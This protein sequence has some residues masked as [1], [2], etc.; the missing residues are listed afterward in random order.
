MTG[1]PQRALLLV[2][3][4]LALVLLI[5]PGGACPFCGMQ[6]P[7][8]TGEVAQAKLV[9]Y[10]QLANAKQQNNGDGTT[11][12]VVETI[13]K[14][15]LAGKKDDL[16]AGTKRTVRLD[17]Y[18]P[19]QAEGGKYRYL[20]YCDVFKGKIDPYRVLPVLKDGDVAKY[21]LGALKHKDE[22]IGKRL[23]FFFDYL[24]NPDLEISNDAYKEFGNADYKD[25]KDMAKSLPAD[26][27]A[28]WLTD[29]KTPAFRYGLYASM[30]GHCGNA[31]HA[32][33]LRKL[34]DDP[35][36]RLGSGVDGMLAGYVMLKPKEGWA[37]TRDILKDGK[38]EFMLRY[39]ALRTVRFLWDSRP[40]LVSKKERTAGMALLLDQSDIADLAVDDMRKRECWDM[41]NRV[42][43]L[44]DTKAYKE[45]PIVRRA[46]LRYALSCKGN[47]VATAYVAEQRKQDAQM[48]AD[49]EELLKL[50]QTPP[51]SG[52]AK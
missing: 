28:K 3:A 10:G 22:T 49:A 31:K 15:E 27:V 17:R 50:E 8:M 6:G 52:P 24:D 39:A 16:L 2:I 43:S 37:Y 51:T 34:L 45:I 41:A 47:A 38:K 14:N 12:L 40:D 48:V 18:L 42:L 5:S 26:R 20:V 9:L 1:L 11:D 21:L 29:P 4:L 7:T 30:L 36:K 32:E 46:V 19:P 35:A 23:R 13:I 25:Y 33:L 44:R